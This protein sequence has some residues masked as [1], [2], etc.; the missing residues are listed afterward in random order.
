[1]KGAGTSIG[2]I[3]VTWRGR[4][5]KMSFPRSNGR[6]TPRMTERVFELGLAFYQ[7]VTEG[8]L[9]EK[10]QSRETFRILSSELPFN[11]R[12]YSSGRN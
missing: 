7:G 3:G 5:P 8:Q 12:G 10:D 11:A 6:D 9:I 4:T 2:T 1:M